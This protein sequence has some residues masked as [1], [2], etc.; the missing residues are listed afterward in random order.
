MFVEPM[1]NGG[2]AVVTFYEACL[3]AGYECMI[4]GKYVHGH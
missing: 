1:M 3:F 4:L 2:K